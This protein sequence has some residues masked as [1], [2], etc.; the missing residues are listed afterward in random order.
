MAIQ[1]NKAVIN[2]RLYYSAESI[3]ELIEYANGSNTF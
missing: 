2:N 3:L 1:I